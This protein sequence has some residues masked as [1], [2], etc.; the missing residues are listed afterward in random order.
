[1]KGRLR[2]WWRGQRQN[3]TTKDTKE[4]QTTRR[5][6]GGWRLAFAEGKEILGAFYRMA[7]A[8][9]KLLQVLIAFDEID[10]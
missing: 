7:E 4:K 1:M 5:M 3:R 8:A 6:R 10:F 9:E 2:V